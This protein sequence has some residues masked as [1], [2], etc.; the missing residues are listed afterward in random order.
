MPHTIYIKPTFTYLVMMGNGGG[1]GKL[2][3]MTV[4]VTTLASS[5][6]GNVALCIFSETNHSY[7]LVVKIGRVKL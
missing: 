4:G 7:C 2:M 3:I 1:Q 6:D 5:R